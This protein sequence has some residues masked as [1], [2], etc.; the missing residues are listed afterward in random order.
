[1]RA[2]FLTFSAAEGRRKKF[3]EP[4]TKSIPPPCFWPPPAARRGGDNFS[5]ISVF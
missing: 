5:N 4:K 3:W 1:M 2:D